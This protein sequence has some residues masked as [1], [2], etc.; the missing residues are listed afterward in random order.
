MPYSFSYAPALLFF[1]AEWDSILEYCAARLRACTDVY[2]KN[3]H[4]IS[5]EERQQWMASLKRE[6]STATF[7]YGTCNLINTDIGGPRLLRNLCRFMVADSWSEEA[8]HCLLSESVTDARHARIPEHCFFHCWWNEGVPSSVTA[9]SLITS[10]RYF[11]ARMARDTL[12]PEQ[13]GFFD[14]RWAT[15]KAGK[16]VEASLERPSVPTPYFS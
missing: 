11:S 5:G 10:W 1:K 9:E 14:Q 7:L 8:L 13:D 6:I 12:L 15:I 3:E 4:S 2:L 16:A